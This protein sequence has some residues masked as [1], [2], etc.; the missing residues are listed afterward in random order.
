L[1]GG[2]ARGQDRNALDEPAA[3]IANTGSAI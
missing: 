2:G 1:A 3:M